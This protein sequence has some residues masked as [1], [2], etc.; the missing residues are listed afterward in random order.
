MRSLIF[1]LATMLVA[2]GSGTASAQ[3][4]IYYFIPTL[5]DEFQTESQRMIEGI[6]ESLGYEVI[7]VDAGADAQRQNKQIL[8]AIVDQPVA[9]II[10]AVDSST[11][12]SVLKK[13]REKKIPVLVY[14]RMLD[15]EDEYDFASVSDAKAIGEL[16]AEEALHLLEPC[17]ESTILQIAGDPG[18][19]YSLR[20]LEGFRTRIRDC[21]D[22]HVF[23][24]AAMEWEPHNAAAI[25]RQYKELNSDLPNLV[26][27]HSG[28]LAAAAIKVFQKETENHTVRFISITGA[29]AGLENVKKGLQQVEIEQPLYAQAYGLAMGLQEILN[30]SAGKATA[31]RNRVCFIMGVPGRLDQDGKVLLLQGQTVEYDQSKPNKLN[32]HDLWGE[33]ARPVKTPE[34]IRALKCELH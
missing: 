26:F 10:N 8:N 5:V 32:K 25:A 16:A 31:L 23:T 13:A 3:N 6:F 9:I 11:I 4:R 20:V 29:P 24:R 7:S 18:D 33:L 34:E 2:F 27:A 12:G 21:R 15:A 19:S 30:V 17:A 28:D 1:T 14:D 22:I